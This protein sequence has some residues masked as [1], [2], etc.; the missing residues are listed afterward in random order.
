MVVVVGG[1]GKGKGG[2]L[3][4]SALEV[5]RSGCCACRGGLRVRLQRRLNL[6]RPFPSLT[7]LLLERRRFYFSHWPPSDNSFLES[8]GV[9]GCQSTNLWFRKLVDSFVCLLFWN[10][11]VALRCEVAVNTPGSVLLLLTSC[12][13]SSLQPG[14]LWP[15]LS[16]HAYMQH[17]RRLMSYGRSA[18]VN[19]L[20]VGMRGLEVMSKAV[21]LY[22]FLPL[23]LDLVTTKL[24]CTITTL[25]L[26]IDLVLSVSDRSAASQNI[27]NTYAKLHTRGGDGEGKE[28]KMTTTA[29]LES[30]N[31]AASTNAQGNV[32]RFIHSER[33][34]LTRQIEN[35]KTSSNGG[36]GA[37]APIRPCRCKLRMESAMMRAVLFWYPPDVTMSMGTPCRRAALNKISS[38]FTMPWQRGT[39]GERVSSVPCPGIVW[40]TYP[41]E[42]SPYGTISSSVKTILIALDQTSRSGLRVVGRGDSFKGELK[43]SNSRVGKLVFSRH[44]EPKTFYSI[45]PA[46]DD[47]GNV[48]EVSNSRSL[49][50]M[51]VEKQWLQ[52]KFRQY[53][54]LLQ[55]RL[56]RDRCSG[57]AG[58]KGRPGGTR[59][60][61]ERLKTSSRLP[62]KARPRILPITRQTEARLSGVESR[63][64]PLGG[65]LICNQSRSVYHSS[66][67]HFT[68]GPDS[69]S[70]RP[71]YKLFGGVQTDDQVDTMIDSSRNIRSQSLRPLN[72]DVFRRGTQ[73]KQSFLQEYKSRDGSL[74]RN[75]AESLKII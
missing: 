11:A 17:I 41:P 1:R 74:V 64:T 63:P 13:G 66:D 69:A 35:T 2:D 44:T 8:T 60:R 53:V 25:S 10:W 52:F 59:T 31:S 16:I 20:S 3:T 40:C 12:G 55:L 51:Q 30:S 26:D 48:L 71:S 61:I 67:H 24:T 73:E 32:E 46:T 23:A 68:P 5:Q 65:G 9:S 28:V 14:P 33:N 58:G 57:T 18:E 22:P 49:P 45:S 47:S 15:R 62:C 29:P 37:S 19:G 38:L 50:G 4:L 56:Q 72:S 21:P 39:R 7:K 34:A 43:G 6:S 70:L 27:K 75:V 54:N 36:C 42:V